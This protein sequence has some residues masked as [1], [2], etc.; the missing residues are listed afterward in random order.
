MM[1][2]LLEE[3]VSFNEQ[4]FTYT[5]IYCF[6]PNNV[7]IWKTR[8]NQATHKWYGTFFIWPT[9]CAVHLDLSNDLSSGIFILAL[10]RFIAWHGKPREIHSDNDTDFIGTDRELCKSPHDLNQYSNCRI[11]CKFNPPGWVDRQNL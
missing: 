5:G 9:T 1:S 7:M 2:D 8:S 10:R 6:G 11:V 4:P 3:R